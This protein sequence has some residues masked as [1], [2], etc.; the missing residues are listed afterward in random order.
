MGHN[1]IGFAPSNHRGRILACLNR[2]SSAVHHQN[3]ATIKLIALSAFINFKLLLLFY[4]YI[5]DFCIQNFSPTCTVL[6]SKS[7]PPSKNK[8]FL[9]SFFLSLSHQHFVSRCFLERPLSVFL[10]C[11][12]CFLV[13]HVLSLERPSPTRSLTSGFVM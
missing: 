9:L 12:F 2:K 7:L 4:E 6:R 3:L 13:E 10:S 11:R 1:K 5:V 8:N